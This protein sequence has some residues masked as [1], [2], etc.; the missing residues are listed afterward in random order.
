MV[1]K[2]VFLTLDLTR[3]FYP[4]YHKNAALRFAKFFLMDIHC[5]YTI[6]AN[7][8]YSKFI[9]KMLFDIIFNLIF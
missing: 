6:H 3:L 1:F 4:I 8:F 9:R 7:L 5:I 2:H